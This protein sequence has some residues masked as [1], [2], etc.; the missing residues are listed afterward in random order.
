MERLRELNIDPNM[1]KSEGVLSLSALKTDTL[2]DLR[3]TLFEHA[4][5]ESL[6]E[7][8]DELVSRRLTRTG[9]PLNGKLADDV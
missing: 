8:G 7:P 9:K 3:V 4:A 5:K 2:L 1:S 6:V